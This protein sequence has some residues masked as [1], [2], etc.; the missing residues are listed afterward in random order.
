MIAVFEEE[1][2][3]TFSEA[4]IEK[5]IAMV[6]TDDSGLIDFSEFLVAAGNE[7]SLLKRERLEHAFDYF[8]ADGSGFL[9]MDEVK[10]FL[11]DSEHT[12][13]ELEYL[14]KKIGKDGG[15]KISK[16]GFI[17]LLSHPDF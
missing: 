11:D 15:T 5:I 1:K 17:E 14:F 9:T 4:E 10:G 2:A 16:K 3:N 12:M 8:D 6:D 7:E 13:K